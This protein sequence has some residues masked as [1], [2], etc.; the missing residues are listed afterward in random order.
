MSTQQKQPQNKKGVPV[1]VIIGG[2]AAAILLFGILF[3]AAKEK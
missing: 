1:G 3:V 2:V